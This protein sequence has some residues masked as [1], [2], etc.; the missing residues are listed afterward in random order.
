MSVAAVSAAGVRKKYPGERGV[1][2]LET[3]SVD[4]PAG[5]FVSILGPSG[6]GKSTFLRCVAGLETISEGELRVAGQPVK[7]P[8]DGIGMVFQ[9]D[10]LL[11]WRNIRRN[12]LLPVEFAGKPVARYR[13]KVDAL[14]RLTGLAAFADNYPRELSGGMRQRAAICR[15]LVDDPAL[16]LMDEPFGALDAL[17]RDQM[18]VELQ[19]IWM[20]TRN[21]V[22]FVTHGIA[23]AVFL[24]DEVMVFSPRPGRV[25]ETIRIDLPRPRPLAV[26]E[27]AEF[28]RYVRHIRGLFEQMGLID[29]GGRAS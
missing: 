13:D 3:I 27:T 1:Q 21:T 12:I 25:L 11:E 6:C 15:A 22:M 19:R 28:G 7:G 10:A 26:R 17:T 20:E 23:E 29:E 4:V 14:L 5:R 18:N 16:L 24:G 9:R 8:P 2:A